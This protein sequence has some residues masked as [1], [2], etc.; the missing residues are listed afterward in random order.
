MLSSFSHVCLFVTRWIIACQAPLSI[1]FSRQEYGSGLPCPSPGN[2]PNPGI[3]LMSLMSL[4][5]ASSIFTTSTTWD[6]LLTENEY[7]VCCIFKLDVCVCTH[8]VM[9]DSLCLHG[10]TRLFCSRNFP[11]K[12]TGA[13]CHLLLQGSS[14][15]RNQT[16]M[17]LLHFLH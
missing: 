6:T 3:E 15:P 17:H 7:T 16:S 1:G 10:P 2:L 13:G 5:L 9:L 14:Q 11:G 12:N 8:S 4:A